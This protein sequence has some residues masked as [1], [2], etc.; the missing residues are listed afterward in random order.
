PLISLTY[1]IFSVKIS[2]Q[3]SLQFGS[4]SAGK[5]QHQDMATAQ[6]E[7]YEPG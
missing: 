2:L 7:R 6:V 1:P 4:D 5:I 3:F